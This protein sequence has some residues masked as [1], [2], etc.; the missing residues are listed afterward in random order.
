MCLSSFVHPFNGDSVVVELV[1]AR[2]KGEFPILTQGKRREEQ[3]KLA[4]MVCCKLYNWLYTCENEGGGGL[5]P[6]R[7][8]D[9]YR[10][11]RVPFWE[12]WL[13]KDIARSFQQ[14]VMS[15]ASMGVGSGE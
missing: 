6:L 8:L 5:Q 1:F 7:C 12:R 13:F 15:H 14:V 9:D 3:L 11:N 10:Y 4:F 2:I